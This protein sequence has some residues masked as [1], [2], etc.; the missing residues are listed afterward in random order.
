MSK[1]G[2]K[3]LPLPNV[4]WEIYINAILA[5][6]LELVLRDPMREKVKH[7]ARSRLCE[8]LL[9]QHLDILKG[10]KSQIEKMAE[11]IRFH[12]RDEANPYEARREITK[13]LDKYTEIFRRREP[14]NV[15]G[16]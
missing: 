7:G 14:A 13:V 4:R 2:R 16:A 11:E 9:Q 5:A 10:A 6:E 3:P 15:S 1:P 12:L 8:V